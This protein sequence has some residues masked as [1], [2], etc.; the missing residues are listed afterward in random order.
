LSSA[1]INERVAIKVT[2]DVCSLSDSLTP[3]N[4]TY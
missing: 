2:L 4:V 3:E 1:I